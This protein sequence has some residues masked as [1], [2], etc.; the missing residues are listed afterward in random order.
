METMKSQWLPGVGDGSEMNRGCMEDL[1]GS[2]KSL[3]DT[4]IGA[5]GH[6]VFVKSHT[7]VQ[8]KSEP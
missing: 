1:R 2:Y 3:C 4:I 5:R 8:L 6:C 7:N